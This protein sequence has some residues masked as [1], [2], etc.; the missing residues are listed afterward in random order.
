MVR[1]SERI[2]STPNFIVTSWCFTVFSIFSYLQAILPWQ[3]KEKSIF[4]LHRVR[5]SFS[6]IQ[7][8]VPG[9]C[10]CRTWIFWQDTFDSFSQSSPKVKWWEEGPFPSASLLSP[11]SREIYFWMSTQGEPLCLRP[12]G[13]GG[14]YSC[15]KDHSNSA[16]DLQPGSSSIRLY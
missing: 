4:C 11:H 10:G 13:R 5:E 16:I 9:F 8:D 12:S 3:K 14:Q 2:L 6:Y 15:E 1:K 7:L